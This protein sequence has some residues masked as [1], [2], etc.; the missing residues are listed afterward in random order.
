MSMVAQM[1]RGLPLSAYVRHRLS[2]V[3]AV[4]VRAVQTVLWCRTVSTMTG[5]KQP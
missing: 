2:S 5:A 1:S 3:S 4:T